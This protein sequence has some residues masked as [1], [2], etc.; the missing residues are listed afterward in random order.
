MTEEKR[1]KPNCEFCGKRFR[2]GK[3]RYTV[4]LEV[5]SDFD[6]YL[7]DL[8]G[9]PENFME[10]RIQKIV[11]DTKDLTEKEI[12]EQVYLSREFLVC[13]G[14]REKFLKILEKLKDK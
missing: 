10:K 12:E 3:T 1:A 14:C 8:S 5:I 2:R 13:V 4:K 7:E 9:K 6:G 11:E